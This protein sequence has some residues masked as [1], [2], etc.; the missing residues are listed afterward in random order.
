MRRVDDKHEEVAKACMLLKGHDKLAEEEGF[1][2]NSVRQ[3]N[4]RLFAD[5][6]P[7]DWT[8][9][10][11]RRKRGSS[12]TATAEKVTRNHAQLKV[13]KLLWN[14]RVQEAWRDLRLDVRITCCW[15]VVDKVI[16]FLPTHAASRLVSGSR[17]RDRFESK[18]CRR[19]RAGV[20][21]LTFTQ[22]TPYF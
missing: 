22:N 3:D 19:R 13:A 18:G 11:H 15:V 1:V 9:P 12:S 7:D 5:M 21:V 4:I 8:P 20:V 17:Q 14:R 16:T 10:M 6:M 2:V